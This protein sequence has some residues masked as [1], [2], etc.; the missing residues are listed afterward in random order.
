MAIRR[1]FPN[2]NGLVKS[3]VSKLRSEN[4]KLKE[5]ID[6]LE[7]ELSYYRPQN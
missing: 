6:E 7:K 2:R 4:K 3:E 1:N 5:Y